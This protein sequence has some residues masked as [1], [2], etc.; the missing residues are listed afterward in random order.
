MGKKK[1][2]QKNIYSKC[3]NDDW[4]K[5]TIYHQNSETYLQSNF[6]PPRDTSPC[7]NTNA[8]N[9]FRFFIIIIII[10]IFAVNMI[11][12]TSVV[13]TTSAR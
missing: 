5:L 13:L 6:C 9:H 7:Y 10:I 12:P 2:Q 3:T 1:Q 4:L 11:W 8:W